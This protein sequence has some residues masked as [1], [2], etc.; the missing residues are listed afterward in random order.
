MRTLFERKVLIALP[1]M[2]AI[3]SFGTMCGFA[4]AVVAVAAAAAGV[5]S[6]AGATCFFFGAFFFLAGMASS[7]TKASTPTCRPPSV[8]VS[9]AAAYMPPTKVSQL[10]RSLHD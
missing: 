8:R 6:G 1:A 4:G 5:V 3:Q 10:K 9:P 2:L 7:H